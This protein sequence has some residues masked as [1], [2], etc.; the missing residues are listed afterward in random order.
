MDRHT[1]PGATDPARALL[2][3][4][5]SQSRGALGALLT[6]DARWWF[7]PSVVDLRSLPRPITGRENIVHIVIADIPVFEKDSSTFEILHRVQEGDLVALHFERI[8]TIRGGS[9]YRAEYHFLVRLDGARVAEVWD[10]IDTLRA[11]D[12]VRNARPPG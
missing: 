12:L 10:I 4:I 2:D 9:P 3:A 6:D 5:G 7:P 8:A 1:D 11:T